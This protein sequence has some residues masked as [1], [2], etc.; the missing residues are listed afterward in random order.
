MTDHLDITLRSIVL[1]CPDAVA[2]AG[3]Y[4]RVLGG[5]LDTSD[6]DWCDVYPEGVGCRLAFQRVDG[7]QAPEWPDGLPQQ[8]HIDL[9][10]KDMEAMSARVVEFGATRIQGPVHEEGGAFIVHLDPAGH[11]FCLCQ[12]V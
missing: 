6:P 12:D 7:Y 8:L 10:V 9:T 3:F 4:H 1:D 5:R 2:L 11:P